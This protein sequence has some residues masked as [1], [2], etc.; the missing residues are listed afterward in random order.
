[1]RKYTL[2]MICDDNNKITVKSE[3]D[4]FNA[5]ELYGLMSW[6]LDDLKS[7]IGGHLKPEDV[8]R[9]IIE[10]PPKPE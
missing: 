9:I 10:R 4:G 6:K 1:M 8:T 7:Q 5:M 3:N 2:E